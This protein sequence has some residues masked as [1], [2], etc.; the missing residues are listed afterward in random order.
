MNKIL[1]L[2]NVIRRM[3]IMEKTLAALQ[4]KN[5]CCSNNK[6]IWITDNTEWN[7]IWKNDL[8]DANFVLVKWMGTILKKSVKIFK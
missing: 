4:R 7:N 1:F 2:T 6:C 3:S 5:D 8:N